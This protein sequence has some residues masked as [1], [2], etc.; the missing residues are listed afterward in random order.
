MHVVSLDSLVFS[1]VWQQTSLH[2]N[3]RI[4]ISFTTAGY[5]Y[6]LTVENI[7]N[8]FTPTFVSHNDARSFLCP[9]CQ[10]HSVHACT[11]LIP[12]SKDLFIRLIQEPSIRLHWLFLPHIG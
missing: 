3:D 2:T 8:V 12:H 10:T 5:A 4:K 6:L 1:H 9:F 7:H 11:S